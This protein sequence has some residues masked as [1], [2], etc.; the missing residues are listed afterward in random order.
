MKFLFN[1]LLL[2]LLVGLFVLPT[3]QATAQL[4]LHDTV[5]YVS[6]D[7]MYVAYLHANGDPRVNALRSTILGDTVAGGGRASATR[8]YYL[9]PGG[10]YYEADDIANN[11]PLTIVS[12]PMNDLASGTYPA[13]IQMA[14]NRED[15]SAGANH[16]LTA[17]DNVT[18]RNVWISGRSN[19]NGTQTAYQPVLFNAN[20][21]TY[22]IDGCV[23]EYSNFALV[24][25]T[26]ANNKC[27]ITNNKFQN[28]QENPVTQQW[29]GRGISIWADQD[30]VIIENNTFFNVGFA[31]FQMEGGSADYL[32]Y[33]HN[34]I[35]GLG[36]GIMSGSGDWWQNAYF[37]NNLIINGFWE[38]EGYA[39]MHG[40]GR[41]PR[42]TYGGLFTIGILPA[43]YGPEQS[44]RVVISKNYAYLDPA[45]I[46]KY[47]T[48]DSITRAWF[49]DPVSNLDYATPY[50]LGGANNGHMFIGD[51]V[52]LTSLPTGFTNYLQDADWLKPKYSLTNAS[53]VD[54]MWQFITNIR[55]G[56]TGGTL[57]FYHPDQ[58]PTDQSWPLTYSG[59]YTDNTLKTAG[60]DGLPIGDLNWFPTD[61][62]TFNANKATYVAALEAKAGEIVHFPIDS[63]S[64]AEDAT[65]GGTAAV[66]AVQGL[67]YYDYAGNGSITWSFNV[68]NAGQYDTRWWVNGTGRGMSGPVIAI[69]GTQVHDKAHMWGQFIF[70]VASGP[71]WG[72][73]NNQ[74]IWVQI[75]AD[76]VGGAATWSPGDSAA[77]TLSAGTNTIAVIN[78][79]WG[80]MYFAGVDVW[81]HGTTDTIHLRAPDAV[82]SIVKPGAVGVTWVASGFKYV[83][84]GTAGTVAWTFPSLD[85]GTYHLRTFYQNTGSAASVD[86]KEGSTVLSTESFGGLAAG[87]GLDNFS[88]GFAL[89]A[90]S[91]TITLS[92][93]NI[94][95]DYVQ[96]IKEVV[97]A[98]GKNGPPSAYALEQNY[99]NPFNPTTTIS[100]SIGKVT[101]VKLRI[102]NLLGQEVATLVDTRMNPGTH[103]VTFDAKTLASGVYF[104]RLEAD[105]FVSVK[106]M[107]LIK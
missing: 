17:G 91:H 51:T 9:K 13:I 93:A 87:T 58:Y 79:G 62:A 70:D 78:G 34:T 42:S 49:I 25:F 89:T 10:L 95:V 69:N 60:T 82:V 39:D 3:Q 76:S 96:L 11:F 98:V 12:T 40:S 24:V 48:P 28:L 52:W 75:T 72:M 73:P 18:L 100:F 61:L 71:M 21:K 83:N 38:G 53:M 59:A 33:N 5:S 8:I 92:G 107:L 85:A 84:M 2:V 56:V 41:D 47:G 99:P 50:K 46:A 102:Y 45:I 81:K 43:S 16:I 44:R 80:E 105:K 29:T 15:G 65:V 66:Q 104:Y 55:N 86:I 35:I 101:N 90:G 88:A 27:Y 32:R 14:D 57:L 74:W 19:V 97:G 26:G 37:G 63:T 1:V 54:S 68:T 36:R 22:I 7:T 64:E 67:T 23:F 103:L 77:F 94:N 106:K 6:N 4:T 31:T 20:N 30:T